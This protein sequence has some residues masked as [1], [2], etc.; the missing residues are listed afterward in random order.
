[1]QKQQILTLWTT[2]TKLFTKILCYHTRAWTVT[3]LPWMVTGL[4]VV[5]MVG[6]A[7]WVKRTVH[8]QWM[9]ADKR[10]SSHQ[11]RGFLPAAGRASLPVLPAPHRPVTNDSR[12][13]LPPPVLESSASK[14][15]P[16]PKTFFLS[17]C[18]LLHA[19][20]FHLL[21]A[22]WLEVHHPVSSLKLVRCTE[23]H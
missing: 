14:L 16:I 6:G 3:R 12:Y 18:C 23:G 15:S 2:L 4:I 1:M 8:S 20:S 13:R 9:Q 21:K 19:V 7:V 22:N 5:N 17:C 11:T 10:R